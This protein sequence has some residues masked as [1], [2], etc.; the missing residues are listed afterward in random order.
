MMNGWFICIDY[1]VALIPAISRAPSSSTLCDDQTQVMGNS[2]IYSSF[3][4]P[5]RPLS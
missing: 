4:L 3:S 1:E 2:K 5:P